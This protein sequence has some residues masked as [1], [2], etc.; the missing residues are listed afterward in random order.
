ML[1]FLSSFVPS[2]DAKPLVW[3]GT[4]ALKKRALD[5]EAAFEWDMKS[6]KYVGWESTQ[7]HLFGEKRSKLVPVLKE[8][9]SNLQKEDATD[10]ANKVIRTLARGGLVTDEFFQLLS[11]IFESYRIIKVSDGKDSFHCFERTRDQEQVF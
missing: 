5:P 6:R 3:D 2:L 10:E 7:F 1:K 8:E 9:Y 11:R 4:S